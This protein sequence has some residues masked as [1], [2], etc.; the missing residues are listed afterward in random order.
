MPYLTAVLLQNFT[1]LKLR[2]FLL[3]PGPNL[4][5]SRL[6]LFVLLSALLF[7]YRCP[8]SRLKYLPYRCAPVDQAHLSAWCLFLS[9]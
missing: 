2:S 7:V 8:C 1:T 9:A 5:T 3:S 4:L 6:Y